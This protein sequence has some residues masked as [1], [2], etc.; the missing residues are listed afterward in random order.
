MNCFVNAKFDVIKVN[1]TE[2]ILKNIY[3]HII[4]TYKIHFLNDISYF[5]YVLSFSSDINFYNGEN[6]FKLHGTIKFKPLTIEDFLYRSLEEIMFD[7]KIY[8]KQELNKIEEKYF[9]FNTYNLY[10][11]DVIYNTNVNITPK[12]QTTL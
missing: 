5:N 3:Y 4:E 12:T 1:L 9:F 8:L 11:F 6:D 2:G 10:R 7:I